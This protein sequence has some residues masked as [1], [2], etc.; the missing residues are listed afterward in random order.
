MVRK[1][2]PFVLLG[3]I[4]SAPF[5]LVHRSMSEEPNLGLQWALHNSGQVVGGQPGVIG[6]DVRALS[7]WS[8]HA[9]TSSVVVAIIGRGIDPHPEFADRLL[10]GHAVVSDVFNTLDTCPHDTH[11]AGIIA[12]DGENRTGIA[13]LN[14]QAWLL[15]VRVFDGCGGTESAAA[16]GIVW[17]VDH[18]ADV[19]LAA[20]QFPDGS[21]EL[22]AAV[23]H[24]VAND[25]IMIA[26]VGSAENNEVAFPAAYDGCIAVSATTNQDTISSVSNF[27]TGVDVSAPGKDIWSTWT[28][29]GF[30]FLGSTRDT[31]AASAMVAGVASLI[32]SYSPG[33]S[34]SEVVQI[35]KNTADDLGATGADDF[36]GAGR[37]NAWRAL[38][39]TPPPALRF[40]YVEP[41]PTTVVP[42]RN[43]TFVIRIANVAK[44]VDPDSA[45]LFH[46]IGMLPFATTQLPPLS[47]SL[48][49]VTLPAASCGETI[50]YYLSAEPAGGS[51][52]F[53]TDP[54]EAPIDTHTVEAVVRQ[55]LFADDFESDL[56]W[57]VE[58]EGL[59]PAQGIWS[60]VIPV[61]T[62]AQPAFDASP[63]AGSVCFV[64]GQ[65]FGGDAGSNDVDHGPVLLMSPAVKLTTA[66]VEISY[67]R[68]FHSSGVG[69]EDF[70]T[71]E[72]SRDDGGSWTQ[73]ESVSSTSAWVL[74]RFRLSDFPQL[75]GDP[76]RVRFSTA[77]SLNDSLTEAAVDEFQVSA[78]RCAM[79]PGDANADGMTNLIDFAQLITCWTGPLE[80]IQSGVCAAVDFDGTFRV[81]L[82]DYSYFQNAID[83]APAQP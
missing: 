66:D 24:A 49:A 83:V 53:V 52:S 2:F 69:Q 23:A 20:V 3:G 65:H 39:Q 16:E 77:D 72:L 55:T 43:H 11:L 33:M 12:A 70:L 28:D 44:T 47:H 21:Q 15:P 30:A 51:G 32:L 75:T 19:V 59:E 76:L 45:R 8:I 27:G 4:T 60:R 9:G 50:E 38:Q 13:G 34:A 61:G 57:T 42:G 62:S 10:Q 58:V 46:R 1:S 29:G 64:T 48:F 18:G 73:V 36:F 71:V 35:L 68:W 81:D 56:G 25:V 80:R 78:I 41:L 74:H 17:A 22:A 37:I 6:A 54:I 63:D 26:P 82:R 79:P 31:A 14:G 67:W 7:A 5:A 40:E